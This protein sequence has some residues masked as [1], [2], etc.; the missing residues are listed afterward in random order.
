VKFLLFPLRL[1]IGWGLSPRL[2]G[3]IG[4]TMLVLLRVSI[5]W[6]FYS[7]GV[8]KLD[9]RNW[10]AAPFFSNAKGPF[11][12][13]YR[14][15]VWDSDGRLRLDREATMMSWA[16]FR[17]QTAEHYGFSEDLQAPL[18]EQKELIVQTAKQES[19][20]LSDEETAT[21]K[22]IDQKLR[23]H[24]SQRVQAQENYIKAVAQ[25]DWVLSE[26]ASN[27]EEFIL[28]RDRITELDTDAHEKPIRDGVTSLGGQRETI[29]RE[30]R[31]KG[32]SALGQINT[33]WGSYESAQNA[34]A[35]EEQAL[36]EPPLR[37]VP[38][39]TNSIDTSIIDPIVPYFDFAIGLCLLLGLFTPVAALAA[40]GFL[41][42]VFL[43]QFPPG[44]GPTSSY[45]Q[46]VECMA[47]LVL[48]GT[49]AGRF[50]GLDYFLHLI[51]RKVWG[52]QAQK[53]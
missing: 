42:S 47:C 46:L 16:V 3:L 12:E 35:S 25:Y 13:Q 4:A 26:N 20:S 14:Q 1:C 49:G 23:L 27:L 51:V 2:L 32:A 38:P 41:G 8:D 39:P 19:R 33:I 30:W 11:A 5:G 53:A 36:A 31:Q 9:A 29:R 52:V 22:A 34:M 45:Y 7:E 50:A 48:A 6:H 43:S 21:V 40:A 37:L 15:L 24:A 17:E 18:I 44:T 10:S 28:G